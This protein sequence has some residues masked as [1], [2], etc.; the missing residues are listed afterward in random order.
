MR[1]FLI[2][3]LLGL[4]FHSCRHSV[5]VN[6]PIVAIDG[7]SLRREEL[8]VTI[9]NDS[10][11]TK[12]I[13]EGK[14]SF[15]TPKEKHLKKIDS[16]VLNAIKTN[17]KVRYRHLK[18]ESLNDYY[19]QY[20]CFI[21]INGDSIVYINAACTIDIHMI[22]DKSNK[23]NRIRDDWQHHLL[24]VDDGGDCYWSVFINLT[25]NKYFRFSV[26]GIA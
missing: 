8:K 18:P 10:I 3:L 21:D 5:T 7:D 4:L 22:I 14:C 6:K 17:F 12:W 23:V 26:N 20:V 2:F 19:R 11:E 24:N 15:W 16:I 13:I 25:K 9:I 1:T